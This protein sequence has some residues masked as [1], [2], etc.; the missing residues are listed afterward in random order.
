[1]TIDRRLL[2]AS[3]ESWIS[4]D[5]RPRAGPWWLAWVW[6]VLFCA[7]LALPFTLVGFL[8]FAREPRAWHDAGAWLQWYGRNFVVA[9]TIGA[10]IHLLFDSLRLLWATPARLAGWAPW[11][12]TAFFTAVPL[13]G[14]VVGWP[15]GVALVGPQVVVR[16]GTPA[17]NTLLAGSALVGLVITAVLHQGFSLHARRIDA[18]RRAA[19]AQ[20]RLL[21]AQIEPHFLF[22][23]LAT[24]QALMDHDTP[25]ARRLLERFTDYLRSSLGA[26]RRADA[27]LGDELDVVGAYLELMTMRMDERLRYEIR[28]DIALRDALLPPLALQPLVENAIHHGLEPKREGGTVRVTA[29]ADG[30]RLVLE[31][32]DD[33]LGLAAPPRRRKGAGV[34]LAN[35]RERLAAL[36]GAEAALEL[37]DAHPGTRA[38]LRLPLTRRPA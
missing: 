37:A 24:V 1:M 6:T 25:R 17:G 5:N 15:L 20:L 19:E 14:V 7:G 21:Q 27:T 26:L 9:F 33:G 13:L 2:R 30:D 29:R 38:T 35:L 8:V 4:H 23:T 31:V 12:R 10:L 11:Q 22:N 16:L 28:A 36:H 34:A 32:H 3:W 18:E